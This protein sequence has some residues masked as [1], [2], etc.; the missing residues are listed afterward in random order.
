MF[1]IAGIVGIG[2]LLSRIYFFPEYFDFIVL[3]QV[4]CEVEEK[5]LTWK[6][7]GKK[8]FYFWTLYRPHYSGMH[9]VMNLVFPVLLIIGVLRLKRPYTDQLKFLVFLFLWI[10]VFVLYTCVDWNNRFVAPV[11]PF[12]I[13]LVCFKDDSGVQG[14]KRS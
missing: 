13:L 6:L 14:V 11:L 3:D 7:M 9:N 2:A 5:T 12:V 10:S 4:I 8:L 1:S